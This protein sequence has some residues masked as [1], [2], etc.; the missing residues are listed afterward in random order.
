M[1]KPLL[2]L[3]FALLSF[4]TNA[5]NPTKTEKI[6]QL[7]ELSGSGKMGIQVMDQMM[8]SFKSSYSVVKQEFWEEFKKEINPDDIEN[9]ILPI[10]DKYYTEADIDQLTAFYKSPIGKKMIQTMPLV[11]RES[12][13]AGQ[14]WG[15]EI[16]TKVLARLKEKGYLE[17]QKELK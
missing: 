3:S 7:L 9:M 15:K 2:I 12:M 17:K 10:Y 13:V 6:K 14:N 5:Q 11:M 16:A 4:T 1:K 8:S